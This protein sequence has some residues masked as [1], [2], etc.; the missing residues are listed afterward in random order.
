VLGTPEPSGAAHGPLLKIMCFSLNEPMG[1]CT[2]GFVLAKQVLY[3]LSHTSSLFWSA[4][5]G[6][7]GLVNYLPRLTLNTSIHLI[8]AFQELPVP[9]QNNVLKCLK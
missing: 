7:R 1:F 5:F 9:G 2:Q 3:C 4:Y 8:A 6:D